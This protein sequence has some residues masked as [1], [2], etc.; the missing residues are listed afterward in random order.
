MHH[1]HTV[2]AVTEC[3]RCGSE[4]LWPMQ[5]NAFEPSVYAQHQAEAMAAMTPPPPA[6][7]R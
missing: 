5:A 3:K 4:P 6:P 7:E 1:P 2:S